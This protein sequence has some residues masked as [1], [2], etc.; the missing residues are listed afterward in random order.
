[1]GV[2]RILVLVVVDAGVGVYGDDHRGEPFPPRPTAVNVFPPH[3]TAAEV[4]RCPPQWGVVG[5]CE[6]IIAAGQ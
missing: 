5:N 1:M 6:F 2:L 3:S 4:H